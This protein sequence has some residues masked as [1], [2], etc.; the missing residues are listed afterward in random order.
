MQI[1]QNFQ[2]IGHFTQLVWKATKEI[3]VGIYYKPGSGTYVV[4]RYYPPGNMLGT[5]AP[6]VRKPIGVKEM[7][8]KTMESLLNTMRIIL[9]LYSA[10]ID[11]CHIFI[12]LKIFDS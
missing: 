8:L 6:N 4:T 3:G 5:F 9:R 12:Q 11:N 2:K 1:M 10:F 7:S